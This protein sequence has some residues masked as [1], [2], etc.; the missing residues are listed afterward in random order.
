M[1]NME[2]KTAIYV[3]NRK[4]EN[5]ED[6]LASTDTQKKII[7]EYARKNELLDNMNIKYNST[8]KIERHNSSLIAMMERIMNRDDVDCIMVKDMERL[9]LD[10]YKNNQFDIMDMLKQKGIQIIE[11][12]NSTKNYH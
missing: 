4:S 1:K 9:D 5:Q 6:R 3:R 12:A 2:R 10:S 11:I 8:D 7:E